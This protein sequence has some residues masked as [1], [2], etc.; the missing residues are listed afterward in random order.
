MFKITDSKKEECPICFE[1]YDNKKEKVCPGKKKS[2]NCEC[3][4]EICIECVENILKK[5]NKYCCP[6]C[7][8][9]LTDCE[10]IQNKMIELKINNQYNNKRLYYTILTI[11]D[12]INGADIITNNI[13]DLN[14]SSR[15]NN[16]MNRIL[17]SDNNMNSELNIDNLTNIIRAFNN[18]NF[19]TEERGI[20]LASFSLD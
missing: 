12:E 10:W 11:R 6:F 14:Y 20:L 13:N 18:R 2:Q 16:I 4:H 19:T 5:N 15:I 1:K 7:R 9:D 17:S 8:E 3:K